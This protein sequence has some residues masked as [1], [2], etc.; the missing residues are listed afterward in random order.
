MKI[1]SIISRQVTAH[2]CLSL[3]PALLRLMLH[4]ALTSQWAR[5]KKIPLPKIYSSRSASTIV[6][7]FSISVQQCWYSGEGFFH[8]MYSILF[9]YMSH[10]SENTKTATNAMFPDQD[11][12]DLQKLVCILGFG[13][14]GK[15][16]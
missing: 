15:V 10:H 1:H 6:F 3:C 4:C 16:G 5:L 11:C 14:A 2:L 9:L 8:W 13:L 12:Y 7:V